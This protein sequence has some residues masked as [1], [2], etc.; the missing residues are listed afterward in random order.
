[1]VWCYGLVMNRG[2]LFPLTLALAMGANP[3]ALL[4]APPGPGEN[5]KLRSELAELGPKL[6]KVYAD[7]GK[8]I[9]GLD[10]ERFDVHAVI[11]KVGRRPERLFEW[12]RDQI[13]QWARGDA[14]VIKNLEGLKLEAETLWNYQAALRGL[15]R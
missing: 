9:R 10:R 11:E 6:E 2:I 14:N 4:P 1:M 12:V 8:S 15:I 5:D 13:A 3:I 7:M